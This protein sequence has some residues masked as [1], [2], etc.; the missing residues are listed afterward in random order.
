[1]CICKRVADFYLDQKLHTL[2]AKFR[3]FPVDV[4]AGKETD[5]RPSL[6]YTQVQGVKKKISWGKLKQSN[7]KAKWTVGLHIPLFASNS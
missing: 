1:M 2:T 3:S 5:C 6:D 7:N 4:R